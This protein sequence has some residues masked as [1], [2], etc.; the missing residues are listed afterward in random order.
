MEMDGGQALELTETASLETQNTALQRVPRTKD[1]RAGAGYG[2]AAG[3][4][5]ASNSGSH[6]ARGT[7]WSELWSSDEESWSDRS[8]GD[9]GLGEAACEGVCVGGGGRVQ[10]GMPGRPHALLRC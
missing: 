3:K 5:L 6:S 2:S 8:S 7:S 1:S 9:L 10:V 4:A